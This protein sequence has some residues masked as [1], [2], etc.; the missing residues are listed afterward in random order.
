M[1]WSKVGDAGC[2]SLGLHGHRIIIEGILVILIS[3]DWT[4]WI[5]YANLIGLLGDICGLFW[6]VWF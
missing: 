3:L 5:W 1:V 4:R 6:M 2:R